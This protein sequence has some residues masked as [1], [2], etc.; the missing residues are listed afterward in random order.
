MSFMDNLGKM[1]GGGSNPLDMIKNLTGDQLGNVLQTGANQLPEDSRAQLGQQLLQ[2]FT[3]HV[4]YT[5][6]GAQAAQAAGTTA[7]AVASGAPSALSSIID[8]AKAHPEVLQ[9]AATA[10][11]TK[12]PQVLTQLLPSL[13]GMF[14]GGAK[15]P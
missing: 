8:Y 9:T 4:P 13:S 5:G 10:F 3:N 2:A 12:N 11:A 15:T 6:D 1:F 14:G 7:D